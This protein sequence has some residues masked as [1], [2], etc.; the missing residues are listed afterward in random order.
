MM[1]SDFFSKN[2]VMCQCP[3]ISEHCSGV[4]VV[5]V[6]RFSLDNTRDF[7]R[8]KSISLNAVA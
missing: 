4:V 1:L 5:V 8:G 7:L 2:V 6:V 3:D